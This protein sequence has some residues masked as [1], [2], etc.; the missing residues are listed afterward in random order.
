MVVD[1][2]LPPR[3]ATS[4][5]DRDGSNLGS[6]GAFPMP[7][8]WSPD[9]KR[10]AFVRGG[11]AWVV[12]TDGTGER[13]MTHFAHGGAYDADWSPDGGSSP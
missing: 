5:S 1:S 8:S 9:A 12:N 6:I 13:N 4:S 2:S 11:D 7:I 3:T 10:F